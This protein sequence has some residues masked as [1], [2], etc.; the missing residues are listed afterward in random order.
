MPC[1][2]AHEKEGSAVVRSSFPSLLFVSAS[3]G[4]DS[5]YFGL[6]VSTTAIS[7]NLPGL[8]QDKDKDLCGYGIPGFKNG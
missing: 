5:G 2:T 7:D 6:L 4:Q 1:F 8:P 3:R